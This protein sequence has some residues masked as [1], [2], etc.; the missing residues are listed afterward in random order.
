MTET[1]IGIQGSIVR[2]QD[3]ASRAGI[4]PTKP[5]CALESTDRKMDGT[6]ADLKPRLAP[7]PS[8]PRHQHAKRQHE[9]GSLRARIATRFT[10]RRSKC[11]NGIERAAP[12]R[13]DRCGSRLGV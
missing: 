7:K 1:S 3:R 13:L 5:T 10:T 12:S 2:S 11:K 8:R 6:I 4:Q 9:Q